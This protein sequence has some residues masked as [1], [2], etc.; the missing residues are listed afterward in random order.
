MCS[1]LPIPPLIIIGTLI[2]FDK[3]LKINQAVPVVF[4]NIGNVLNELKRF[5]DAL[6]SYTEAIRIE[7]DNAEAFY[8][9]GLL[10]LLNCE[11]IDGVTDC[12]HRWN[13]KDFPSYSIK[14]T[15]PGCTPEKFGKYVLIW[16]EQ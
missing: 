8:N 16:A 4:N 10:R 3:A 12:L 7:P 1:I 5:D 6:A 9:R 13:S 14:T 15:L 11:F 2:L